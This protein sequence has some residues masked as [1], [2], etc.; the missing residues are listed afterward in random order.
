MYILR[1]LASLS[2]PGETV[3]S[4]AHDLE[5]GA[6]ASPAPKLEGARNSSKDGPL[7]ARSIFWS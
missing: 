4:S 3:T 6:Y 7:S 5:G 1:Y 2:T